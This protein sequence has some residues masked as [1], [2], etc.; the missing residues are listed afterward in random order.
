MLPSGVRQ[1]GRVWQRGARCS[2]GTMPMTVWIV[3]WGGFDEECAG[4]EDAMDRWGQLDAR[5]IEA[6]V[7]RVTGEGTERPM[8]LAST[9]R[10]AAMR[11]NATDA[12]LPEPRDATK[13]SA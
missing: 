6:E 11:P 5:G 7:V 9:L 1:A 8:G 13:E 4:R 12:A 10:F 2:V 3:R